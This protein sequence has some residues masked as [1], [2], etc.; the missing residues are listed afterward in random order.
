MAADEG[1]AERV[2]RRAETEQDLVEQLFALDARLLGEGDQG[3]GVA[4]AS[5][6]REEIA[7]RVDGGDPA[8]EPG[9]VAEGADRIDVMQDEAAVGRSR[10]GDVVVLGDAR[11]DRG[12]GRRRRQAGEGGLEG[13]G[14]EL[15]GAAAAARRDTRRRL[16]RRSCTG[17][18]SS[19]ME[20]VSRGERRERSN[21]HACRAQPQRR[22]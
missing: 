21:A 12:V 13:L 3:L 5:A 8:D 19:G 1:D 14:G 20:R 7:R 15:R 9:V 17:W 11:D 6:L 16:R 2:E 18:R 10:D 4:R 22:Q